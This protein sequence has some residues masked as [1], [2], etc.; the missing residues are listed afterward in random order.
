M[1][2]EQLDLNNANTI[3]T[4]E[5]S[6]SMKT[7]NGIIK[8]IKGNPVYEYDES[9]EIDLEKLEGQ[10]SSWKSDWR[11]NFDTYNSN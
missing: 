4:E 2:I 8:D 5:Y 10:I 1:L 6:H 7:K 9:R 3:Y 11:R